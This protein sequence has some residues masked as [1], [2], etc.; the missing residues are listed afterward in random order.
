M[1][2]RSSALRRLFALITLAAG[3]AAAAPAVHA[4]ALI[5]DGTYTD[6]AST[7]CGTTHYCPLNSLNVVP[8]GKTLIVRNVSCDISHRAATSPHYLYLAG[9]GA[10]RTNLQLGTPTAVTSI[11][12]RYGFTIETFATFIGGQRPNIQ[13]AVLS[14]PGS[15]SINCT[16]AGEVR[17]G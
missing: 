1:I 8:T 5:I 10:R 11:S 7:G 9:N 4:A 12:K 14:Q 6:S 17:P 2:T 15:I 3:T 13:F 16:I